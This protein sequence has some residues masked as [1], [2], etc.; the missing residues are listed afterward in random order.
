[1]EILFKLITEQT[2]IVPKTI[3]DL[4]SMD[5]ED[6]NKLKNLFN[7]TDN[8]IWIVE[9]STTQHAIIK[10]TYP[11]FNLVTEA[12][13]TEEGVREFNQVNGPDA[14]T[15]SLYDRVDS[16]YELQGKGLEKRLVNTITGYELLQ[17]INNPIDVCKLDVEGLTYEVLISF[18][19]DL[20]KIKSFHIECEHKEV[21]ENQRLYDEVK[22]YLISKNY[23]QIYFKFVAD[24][25]LQSDSIWVLD[26][27][28]I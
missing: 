3:L 27:Y 4:G 11:N 8:D 13:Y 18:G 15:S 14:G 26:K 2:N 10:E 5:G 16:W 24:G 19:D 28:L 12:I 6:A 1:M 23:K 21:W 7:L 17:R 9:P 25:D 20:F 22:D